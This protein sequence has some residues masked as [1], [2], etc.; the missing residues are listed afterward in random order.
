[1]FAS[2]KNDWIA[3]QQLGSGNS[4][5]SYPDS[6]PVSYAAGLGQLFRQLSRVQDSYPDSYL[7]LE[8]LSRQLSGVRIAI[9]IAINQLRKRK[10]YCQTGPFRPFFWVTLTQH[11]FFSQDY[12]SI[13][14]CTQYD[15]GSSL[16][17]V[18]F[19]SFISMGSTLNIYLTIHREKQ[20]V[21]ILTEKGRKRAELNC[22]FFHV[23]L[24]DNELKMSFIYFIH[25]NYGII[26]NFFKQFLLFLVTLGLLFN[27][28]KFSL[29]QVSCSGLFL[30]FAMIRVRALVLWNRKPQNIAISPPPAST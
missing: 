4:K 18:K 29:E 11:N 3:I 14:L 10:G 7:G 25:H 2:P 1:M 27:F 21:V 15:T 23:I 13:V 6:Y 24:Y 16:T 20:H 12:F 17:P 28:G 8:Q 5:V 26:M 22:S 9:R 30:C 19:H